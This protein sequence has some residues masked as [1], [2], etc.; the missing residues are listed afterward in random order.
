MDTCDSTGER[1][2]Q[3][4]EVV[5]RDFSSAG[6]ASSKIKRILQQIGVDPGTVRRIAVASY[7]AEMNV[8]IHADSGT[9]VLNAGP[10]YVTIL[11]DDAG[12]GIEDIERA[13]QPGFSTASDEIRE[14]GFGAGMGL[15]NIKSCSDTFEINSKP[16]VGT[17]LRMIFYNR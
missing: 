16:G 7:E 3:S 13:M 6:S 8:V 15:P 9:I 2:E 14:M 17:T 1:L 12:P 5:G 4:F 10:G 11:V